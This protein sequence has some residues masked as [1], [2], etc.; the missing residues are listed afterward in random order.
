MDSYALRYVVVH[1]TRRMP[2]DS[3]HSSVRTLKD[4][5]PAS[6]SIPA[7]K[8]S[9]TK[10]KAFTVYTPFNTNGVYYSSLNAVFACTSSPFGLVRR[11]A[12]NIRLPF[13]AIRGTSKAILLTT[14][15]AR[16]NIF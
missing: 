6:S 15:T 8:N 13:A 14:A 3:V 12:E 16:G 10:G 5:S 9:V 11:G 7:R 1:F 2:E 4:D